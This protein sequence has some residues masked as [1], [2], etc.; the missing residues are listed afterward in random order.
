[1]RRFLLPLALLAALPASAQIMSELGA[2]VKGV[3]DPTAT[4]EFSVVFC[5][6]GARDTTL[7]GKDLILGQVA[8][9]DH[10]SFAMVLQ[11][12]DKGRDTVEVRI[13]G[14]VQI[15]GRGRTGRCTQCP[16]ERKYN[17]D[18]LVS[19][20]AYNSDIC[21]FTA[22]L[23]QIKGAS[24]LKIVDMQVGGRSVPYMVKFNTQ[25]LLV[26]NGLKVPIPNKS[27]LHAAA[28]SV[29]TVAAAAPPPGESIPAIAP[30]TWSG[31]D[32]AS[33]DREMRALASAGGSPKTRL[34]GGRCLAGPFYAAK[35]G[36][37][38]ACELAVLPPV[39]G[40]LSR[41]VVEGPGFRLAGMERIRAFAG[42]VKACGIEAPRL[43]ASA[44]GPMKD[45]KVLATAKFPDIEFVDGGSAVRSPVRAVLVPAT[46]GA[47]AYVRLETVPAAGTAARE[48]LTTKADY[49]PAFLK[50]LNPQ[51]A[52]KLLNPA[53]R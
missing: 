33:A 45:G 8:S 48:I 35:G 24:T 21:L 53:A 16:R 40:D 43:Q 41:I 26:R 44:G 29:K 34:E 19:R 1:M 22:V 5:R 25:P 39:G 12:P 13:E 28:V 2:Y 30:P 27:S 46:G 3:W 7:S 36:T 18:T 10:D 9:L 20:G 42:A 14:G 50:L 11:T 15:F 4:P 6:W 17:G 47:A 49:L 38:R 51:A 23:D 32:E 37:F 52:L 31:T